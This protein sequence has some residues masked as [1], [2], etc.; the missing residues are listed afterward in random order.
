MAVPRAPID[1]E[2]LAEVCLG[3]SG[4]GPNG[5]DGCFHIRERGKVCTR[6]AEI[7]FRNFFI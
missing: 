2:S 5:N 1:Y 6:N 7:S 3:T 4:T